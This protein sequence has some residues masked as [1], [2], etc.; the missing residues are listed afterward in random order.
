VWLNGRVLVAGP[1]GAPP[2]LR[3]EIEIRPGADSPPVVNLPPASYAFV[4]FPD[5]D[6]PACR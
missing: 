2:A 5:A 3:P 6:A 4:V 1:D